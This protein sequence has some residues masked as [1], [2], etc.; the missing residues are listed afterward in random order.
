MTTKSIANDSGA[1]FSYWMHTR[2]GTYSAALPAEIS[3]DVCVI[4]AG[5]AGVTTAYLLAREG[6]RVVILDD[7]PLGG[8]ETGRTTA[9]L[10]NV[11]D[12]RFVHLARYHGSGGARLIQESHA[13]AISEIEAICAREAIDCAFQRV[14]GYLFNPPGRPD[15]FLEHE[16]EAARRAGLDGERVERAPIPSFDTGP[17]LRFRNQAQLHPLLYLRGLAQAVERQRAPGQFYSGARVTRIEPGSPCRVIT[18]RGQVVIAGA[19]V[20]ATNA[21]INSPISLPLKQAPYRTYAISFA[22][23]AGVIPTALYWDTE[24][25]YHYVRLAKGDAVSGAR[26][27]LIVG[28]EDH[29]TGQEENPGERFERL[30]A[31]TRQRFPEAE[32]IT[33]RWSGQVLEPID[34][35]G[36][37]GKSPDGAPHVYVITGD[38]GQGMTN[39][40]LGAM[41]VRDLVTNRESPWATLYDPARKTML[42][43]GEYLRENANVMIQY[44]D[45]LRPGDVKSVREIS[46]GSGAIV[47]K[48]AKLLAVYRDH[49]GVCHARSAACTHLAGIVN[50]N[51][52]EK[53]WDCPCHGSRFDAFGRVLGGPATKDLLVAEL[54]PDVDVD[55]DNQSGTADRE[56]MHAT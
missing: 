50:W 21:P 13:A 17:A 15:S 51:A 23:P 35:I 11:Q 56:G 32:A 40:T 14:D 44:L 29:K 3:A 16:L 1:S 31:W 10:A 39:G 30:E 19:V 24:D 34:G 49:A 43:A 47:R 53:S 6:Q 7:G 38:S 25:P 12:D 8:G 33:D 28:G 5:L 36:Y 55:A 9:H 4:G 54:A 2:V 18:E 20:V 46:R 27:A 48:G 37:N 22:V 26:D 41:L 45:W 42:A 52:V